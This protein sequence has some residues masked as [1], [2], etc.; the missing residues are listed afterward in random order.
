MAMPGQG[1]GE[2]DDAQ[3]GM[4]RKRQA[5][6]EDWAAE[7]AVGKL[8]RSRRGGASADLAG[9]AAGVLISNRTPEIKAAAAMG[10]AAEDWPG[11]GG[12]GAICL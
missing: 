11:D 9:G 7:A 8:G 10:W 12:V 3:P 1:L 2:Q 4:G 6:R 5:G